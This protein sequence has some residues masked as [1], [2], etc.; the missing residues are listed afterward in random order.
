[1][2]KFITLLLAVVM[3]LSLAACNGNNEDPKAGL[4]VDYEIGDTGGLKVPF[5]NGE[6]IE[7]LI[8]DEVGDST[9]YIF[10]KLSE[11]VGLNVKPMLVPASTMTQKLSVLLAGGDMPDITSAGSLTKANEYGSQGAFIA[12]NDYLD[13][14]PNF[15]RCF[16]EE[17]PDNWIFKSL[18]AENKK[19]YVFPTYYT[20]R[21][22]NHGML[23]R[24]DIFDKHGIEMWDSPETFYQALKKLKEL[25]PSSYPLTSKTGA[26]LIQNYAVAWGG[27]RSYGMYYN[28][29]EKTWKYSDTDPK[30]KEILDYFHKLYTEG[31]LDPEFLTNT[32][33]AWTQRMTT[34]SSFVTYDWIGRLD[35]FQEQST[36][37]GYDLRYANP[38]GPEQTL[39]TLDQVSLGG[40]VITN[41][42]VAD[43]SVKLMDFFYS[44]AGAELLTCGIRGETFE[45][46]ETTGMAKYLDP[47]L[48]AK[49]KV[50]IMDL[51]SK[52][53]MWMSGSYRRVDPR[54]CYFQFTERE[55]EAQDWVEKC[56][57][58]EP[59][60]PVV[61]FV[62]RTAT[63]ANDI[64]QRLSKE[65][66]EVMFK[67]IVGTDTGDAAWNKWL[68]QAKKLGEDDICKIYND[69]HKELGL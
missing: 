7:I 62:G 21:L 27:I 30:T 1:M 16:G 58:L 25:Y 6:E 9:T 68:H 45:I 67:Y 49:E 13:E 52:Y 38:V 5:G 66:E 64:I 69:R 4:T 3:V 37:P 8:S 50:D 29:A 59:A 22:V 2:K 11:I 36:I 19:L 41:N 39:V 51:R 60:D 20:N 18:A 48:Q 44:D 40:N 31:L 26:K 42:K 47:E 61:T 46:D 12:V 14:M 32:Q 57:G 55:Q 15:N 54:S 63:D 53:C 33:P 56:G 43:L 24:K 65:F 17:S 34:G 10:E 28:E 23:Y 35:M